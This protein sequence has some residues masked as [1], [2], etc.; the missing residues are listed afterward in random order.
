MFNKSK[1]YALALVFALLLSA[2]GGGNE[3]GEKAKNEDGNQNAQVSD[4]EP[5]KEDGV[6]DINIA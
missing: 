4:F 1:T 5:G 3:N 2:C 6:Y